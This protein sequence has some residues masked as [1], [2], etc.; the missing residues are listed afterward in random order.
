MD[1]LHLNEQL[2]CLLTY[3]QNA[4]YSS[5][6]IDYV[7]KFGKWL[8]DNF[9]QYQ[10]EDYADVECTLADLWSN[11]YT[12]R[13]KV[14]LL[15]VKHYHKPYH[16]DLLNKEYRKVVELSALLST[17]RKGSFEVLGLHFV[18]SFLIYKS[19]EWLLLHQ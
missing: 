4:G 8:S 7:S 1:V 17:S 11:K 12:L 18:P 3:L 13:N 9:K 2:P 16:Y 14:R 6:Y 5:M 19:M 15:R 10:W